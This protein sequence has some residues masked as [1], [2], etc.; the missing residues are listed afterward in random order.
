MGL[1]R[2]LLGP[3]L[4]RVMQPFD[5]L[6]RA[7]LHLQHMGDGMDGPEIARVA[8]DRLPPPALRFVI[9]AAFLQRIGIHALHAAVSGH[10]VIPFAEHARDDR[11]H[12]LTASGIEAHGVMQLERQQVARRIREDLLPMKARL[13][14]VAGR[15]GFQRLDVQTLAP[16]GSTRGSGRS[17]RAS[18]GPSAGSPC[19]PAS[20]GNSRGSTAP[21]RRPG[22]APAPRGHGRRPWSDSRDSR[23]R[24]GRRAWPRSRSL[25]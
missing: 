17:R 7:A 18:A 9:G 20:A 21:G 24:P 8:L 12:D 19:S 22:P 4:R 25:W 3:L 11:A 1:E 16:A 2:I 13:H 6:G 10:L 5:A 14:D 23:S 15:P